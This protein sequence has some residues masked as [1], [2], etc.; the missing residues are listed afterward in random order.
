MEMTDRRLKRVFIP[1]ELVANVFKEDTQIINGI[2]KDAVSQGVDRDGARQG[3]WVRFSHH[4]FDKVEEGEK[5]PQYDVGIKM[6]ERCPD[7]NQVKMQSEIRM[8]QDTEVDLYCPVCD[9]GI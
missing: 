5:I 9:N 3:I 2:P 1:D 8:G 6:T 7:C 4:S